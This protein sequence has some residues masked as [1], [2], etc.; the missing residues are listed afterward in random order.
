MEEY[1]FVPT[2]LPS[3]RR[4][5]AYRQAAADVRL[6]AEAQDLE[7]VLLGKQ[8]GLCRQVAWMGRSCYREV[9]GRRYLVAK[10]IGP[11][12]GSEAMRRLLDG[13]LARRAGGLG[14]CLRLDTRTHYPLLVQ[15]LRRGDVWDVISPRPEGF[16][17]FSLLYREAE[18]AVVFRHLGV[19][20]LSP[21][22]LLRDRTDPP[23]PGRGRSGLQDYLARHLPQAIPRH[24]N[25]GGGG[26]ASRLRFLDLAY[27]D[28]DGGVLI[29]SAR[30]PYRVAN[31]HSAALEGDRDSLRALGSHMAAQLPC[32]A[33]FPGGAEELGLEFASRL[34]RTAARL[35]C[36]GALHGQL[37]LHYQNVT[38][39]GELADFDG[40]V[41]LRARPGRVENVPFADAP[42]TAVYDSHR[43]QMESAEERGDVSIAAGLSDDYQEYAGADYDPP[44]RPRLAASLLRQIYDCYTQASRAADLLVR[45]YVPVVQRAG[46]ALSPGGLDAVRNR[47]ARS[48]AGELARRRSLPLLGWCREHGLRYLL[49]RLLD[50]E[51]RR[52]IYG[53]A[54]PAV[55]VD[56]LAT[57]CD[58][59]R[60][61]YIRQEASALLESICFHAGDC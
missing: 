60:S 61:R 55:P 16:S 21:L 58:L 37:H 41:F 19:P 18:S 35:F 43:R 8:R 40:A 57:P 4:V 39:A 29:R 25:G 36:E 28:L 13:A 2:P 50:Q 6:E 44:D 33:A 23:W 42:R 53:W 14:G 1:T 12:P 54:S 7:G 31:L 10:G 3:G 34:A 52:T 9:A 38:L 22:L 26:P 27:A 45:A 47:F 46:A 17:M 5:K 11:S 48:C 49:G 24:L 51:G 32:R 56:H 59:S 15:F 20:A 30:S